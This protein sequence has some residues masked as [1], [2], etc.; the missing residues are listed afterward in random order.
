MFKPTEKISALR[1]QFINDMTQRKLKEKT[2]SG[3]IRAIKRLAIFLGRS[4]G[5]ATAE[6]I[7]DYQYHLVKSNVSNITINQTIT[8]IR[9]FCRV[10]LDKPELSRKLTYLKEPHVIPVVLSVAEV[11]RLLNATE[12][13]RE[14]ALPSIAYGAGLRISEVTHLRTCDV[15]SERMLLYVNQGKGD[16]DRNAK[17][18]NSLVSILKQWWLEANAQH[19]MF[20]NGWLFPGK[21]PSRPLSNR[22]VSRIFHNVLDRTNIK[23]K[24]SMHTLRHSFATHL[25]ESGTDIRIIQVLLGHMNLSTTARYSHVASGLIDKVDSPLDS[26]V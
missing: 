5:L 9:L 19:K 22:Q 23:K 25:L 2:Q 24:A 8:A 12:T 3:Y 7:R 6:E 11:T 26:I 15:D 4:P 20:H 16:R 10:T 17:L 18:S 1:Q 13:T 14:K 21:K